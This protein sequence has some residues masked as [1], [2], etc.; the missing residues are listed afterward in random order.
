VHKICNTFQC[1]RLPF[2]LGFLEISP[3][4]SSAL[5]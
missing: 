3:G 5:A 4:Y 2:S 1:E